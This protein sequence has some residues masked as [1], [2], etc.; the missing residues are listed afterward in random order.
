ME[1]E[2][3]HNY[4]ETLVLQRVTETLGTRGEDL[5]QEQLTDVVCLA[6]NNLPPR[7]VRHTVDYLSHLTPRELQELEAAADQAIVE[8]AD[9][10]RRRRGGGER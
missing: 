7:Y 4:V 5:D 1:L 9:V 6:L 10:I 8:A 3:V 2:S